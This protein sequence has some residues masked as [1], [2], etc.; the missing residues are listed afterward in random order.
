MKNSH[1]YIARFASALCLFLFLAKANVWLDT[2]NNTILVLGYRFFILSAPLFFIFCR[3]KSALVSFVAAAIGILLW[4]HGY[5]LF[6]TVLIAAGLAV[7]GYFLKY[8]VTKTTVGAAANKIALNIGSFASGIVI[9]LLPQNQVMFWYI[10]AALIII[11]GFFCF[12]GLKDNKNNFETHKKGD[13]SFREFFTLNG[14]AWALI[15]FTTGVKLIATFSILPQYL[16]Q[17]YHVLPHWYGWTLAL[18]SL[19]IVF[20][21]IPIIKLM[22]GCSFGKSLIPLFLSMLIIT[23]TSFFMVT[24]IWGAVIWTLLLS[25]CE[26]AVSYLDKLS[27]HRKGLF[28][29]ESFVGI[30]GALTVFFARYLSAREGAILIGVL[31][32]FAVLV[33]WLIFNYSYK[34]V[35]QDVSI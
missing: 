5:F 19:I 25:L 4:L 9:V 6:G 28:V 1:L 22:N 31:G 18:N 30:G 11:S 27:V 26:C 34:K 20:L 23:T 15:G 13:F 32:C 29:K 7:S 2:L 8:Y 17:T 14:L 12:L 24:N 21:Q 33:S 3:D 35:A 10:G 16:I